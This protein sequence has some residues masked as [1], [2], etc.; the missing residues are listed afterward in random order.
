[1][2]F[3]DNLTVQNMKLADAQE[4]KRAAFRYANASLALEGLVADKAQLARQ[5]EII[6]GRLTSEQAVA[7]CLAEHMAAEAKKNELSPK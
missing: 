3:L 1:M 7:Q 6:H 2:G 4:R 5:E